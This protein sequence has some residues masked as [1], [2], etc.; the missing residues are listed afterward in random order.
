V[1][2]TCASCLNK[3]AKSLWQSRNITGQ[4]LINTDLSFQGSGSRG[5]LPAPSPLRTVRESF[6]S[7]GSSL[8]KASFIGRPAGP[9]T[10]FTLLCDCRNSVTHAERTTRRR[11][12]L[13]LLSSDS[14]TSHAMRHRLNVS[15]LTES[16]TW[17]DIPIVTTGHS[18]LSASS[19]RPPS[20]CLA[21][22]PARWAT[23][24]GFPRSAQLIHW[25]T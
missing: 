18:L 24:M 9:R 2:K 5:L 3:D 20:A 11:L 14:F 23:D 1:E 4:S 25:M 7:H 10:C 19:P 17:R 8:S 22:R 13:S 6:P 16:R 21:V 12:L 15:L